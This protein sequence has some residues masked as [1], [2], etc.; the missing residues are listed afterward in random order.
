MDD[1]ETTLSHL[2]RIPEEQG[3]IASTLKVLDEKYALFQ[4]IAREPGLGEIIKQLVGRIYQAYGTFTVLK[5][6]RILEIACGSSSSKAPSS[7]FINTPFGEGQIPISYTDGYTAQFE[8]WFCR[9][10]S[11]GI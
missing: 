3:L 1:L 10:L 7:I 2:T 9:I 8:P 11:D 6:K 5:G 4:K